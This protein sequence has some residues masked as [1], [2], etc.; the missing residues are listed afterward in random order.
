MA[1]SVG[2]ELMKRD[3]DATRDAEGKFTNRIS[4]SRLLSTVS[5]LC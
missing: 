3:E 2:G 4:V 1:G 5:H